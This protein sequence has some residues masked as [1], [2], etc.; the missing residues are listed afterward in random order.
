VD[1][2]QTIERVKRT[3]MTWFYSE[4]PISEQPFMDTSCFNLG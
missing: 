2:I 4:L 1:P 3:E